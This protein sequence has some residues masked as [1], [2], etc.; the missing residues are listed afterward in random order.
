MK[1]YK[2]AKKGVLNKT[3]FFQSKDYSAK[4][5]HQFVSQIKEIESIYK[6]QN[7][8]AALESLKHT[9]S[10]ATHVSMPSLHQ[11]SSLYY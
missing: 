4:W 6:K 7:L 2:N 8:K 10:K 9:H 1:H 11:K 3:L 5:D